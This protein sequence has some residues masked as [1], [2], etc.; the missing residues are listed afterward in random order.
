ML[1]GRKALRNVYDMI[2][3][4][5]RVD[6]NFFT[7]SHTRTSYIPFPDL[8]RSINLMAFEP[9]VITKM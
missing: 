1:D 7:N 4:K 9:I 8:Y 2:L 5:F 3:R 6:M